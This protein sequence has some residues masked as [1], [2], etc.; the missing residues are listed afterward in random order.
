MYLIQ[1]KD[2]IYPVCSQQVFTGCCITLDNP[3]VSM[4]VRV[5]NRKQICFRCGLR[6]KD[7]WTV[8]MN[9]TIVGQSTVNPSVN[10]NGGINP[11]MKSSMGG[12]LLR[13]LTQ[14]VSALQ[15]SHVLG[16]LTLALTAVV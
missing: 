10:N 2:K 5:L 11:I 9:L 15:H 13:A 1:I 14:S 16:S 7:Y 8:S 4:T 3:I 6:I 12:S